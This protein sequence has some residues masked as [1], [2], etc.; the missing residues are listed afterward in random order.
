MIC[1]LFLSAVT[2]LFSST[3][4]V[5][6]TSDGVPTTQVDVIKLRAT[7]QLDV[8]E[9]LPTTQVDVIDRVTKLQLLFLSTL[10]ATF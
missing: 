7:K 1:S 8:I 4:G 6:F 3:A 5:R 9:L 10:L 2:E